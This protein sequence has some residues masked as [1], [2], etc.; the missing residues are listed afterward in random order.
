[1]LIFTVVTLD[2]SKLTR[3][4]LNALILQNLS[5]WLGIIL[6]LIYEFWWLYNNINFIP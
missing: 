4:N 1:M 2:I 6:N 3:R 5:S